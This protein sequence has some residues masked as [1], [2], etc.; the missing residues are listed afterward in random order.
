M[1]DSSIERT[2]RRGATRLSGTT[3][4]LG[5]SFLALTTY[6]DSLPLG[7][8]SEAVELLALGKVEEAL[9]ALV[10]QWLVEEEDSSSREG[11]G[12]ER[13]GKDGRVHVQV[14]PG[15]VSRC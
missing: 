6:D 9:R 3:A 8:P 4:A 14:L 15:R 1:R 13:G 2:F 5:L 7:N 11:E 10:L 12:R